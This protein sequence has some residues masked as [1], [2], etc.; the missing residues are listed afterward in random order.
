[1]NFGP[2]PKCGLMQIIREKC[3]SCGKPLNGPGAAGHVKST[4]PPGPERPPVNAGSS[5]G[6]RVSPPPIPEPS[7][8][9][10]DES[11][12]P[13]MPSRR[14]QNRGRAGSCPLQE[15]AENSSGYSWSIFS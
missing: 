9:A 11:A 14:I 5:P 15:R 3:Q 4:Q 7:T 13:P 12:V 8:P 2:C 10:G 6:E 1:M